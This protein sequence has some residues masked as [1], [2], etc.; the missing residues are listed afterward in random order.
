MSALSTCAISWA[1]SRVGE[2]CIIF[3]D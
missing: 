3:V 2:M 1:L